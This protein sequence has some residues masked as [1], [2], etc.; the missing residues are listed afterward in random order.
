MQNKPVHERFCAET[1]QSRQE[2]RDGKHECLRHSAP[3]N[4]ETPEGQAVSESGC[5]GSERAAVPV[6]EAFLGLG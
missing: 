1:S 3:Q 6:S 4:V 5:Q 2:C